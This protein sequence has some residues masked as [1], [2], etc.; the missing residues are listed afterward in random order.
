MITGNAV[1]EFDEMCKKLNIPKD[2]VELVKRN[3]QLKGAVNAAIKGLENFV[4]AWHEE[5]GHSDL[6]PNECSEMMCK[7]FNEQIEALKESLK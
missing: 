5:A 1:K 6:S 3:L 7:M 4:S 2:R